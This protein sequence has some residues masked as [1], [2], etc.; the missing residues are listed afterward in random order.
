MKPPHV[1]AA[2]KA[3]LFWKSKQRESPYQPGQHV[4]Y[5]MTVNGAEPIE[6]VRSP[7]DYE[8]YIDKQLR[9]VVDAILCFKHESLDDLIE[10]QQDL[11][12]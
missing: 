7:I 6:A 2:I 11:F 3:E 1:Q 4:S 10:A 9:P 5:V 12:S 8:H